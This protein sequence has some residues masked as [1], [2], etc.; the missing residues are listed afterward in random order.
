MAG[1]E[2][3]LWRRGN[4]IESQ[5]E[6]E[7]KLLPQSFLDSLASPL[8]VRFPLQFQLHLQ[9]QQ[10]MRKTARNEAG[11][12]LSCPGVIRDSSALVIALKIK[13]M[14]MTVVPQWH[15]FNTPHPWSKIKEILARN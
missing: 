7:R 14:D 5:A 8:Q 13:R 15:V 10:M 9:L 3:E 1:L 12:E 4:S 2:E 11:T 6:S